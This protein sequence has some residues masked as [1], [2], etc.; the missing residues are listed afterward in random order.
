M[1]AC[2]DVGN[3]CRLKDR[4]HRRRSIGALGHRR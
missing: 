4:L 2:V 1:V 3:G